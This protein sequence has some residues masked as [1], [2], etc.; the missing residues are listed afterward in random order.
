MRSTLKRVQA[1]PTKADAEAL[2]SNFQSVIDR[3]LKKGIIHRNA[4]ARYKS[5]LAH[6]IAALEA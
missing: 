3:T 1:A 6:H 4:A 2:F 5:R